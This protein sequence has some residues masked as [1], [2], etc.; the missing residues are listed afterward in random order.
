MSLFPPAVSTRNTRNTRTWCLRF[1]NVCIYKY[2][3]QRKNC[4]ESKVVE[5]ENA[6]C[7]S[8]MKDK[9]DEKCRQMK[10]MI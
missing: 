6:G 10:S 9:Y 3:L 1:D 5:E 8:S 7:F 2:K 4:R